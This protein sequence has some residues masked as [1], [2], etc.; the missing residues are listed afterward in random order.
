M[1][2]VLETSVTVTHDL[3]LNTLL[4]CHVFSTKRGTVLAT[5]IMNISKE[6]S[7]VGTLVTRTSLFFTWKERYCK[8]P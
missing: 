2:A 5:V 4:T 1:L 8:N 3:F 7:H 6:S